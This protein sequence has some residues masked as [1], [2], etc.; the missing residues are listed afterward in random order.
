MPARPRPLLRVTRDAPRD[1][2]DDFARIRAE[3]EVPEAFPAEVE[4]AARDAAGRAVDPAGRDDLRDLAFFTVDPPG[5]MDLDQAMHLERDGDGYRVRYAIA[6]VAA[7]VDR[8]GPVE[9]EAWK[10]G[11]TIYSPDRRTPL[12]PPALSEGAGSL[13]PE[14]ERPA[15]LFTI[16]LDGRGCRRRTTVR[17]ALVRSAARRT[18]EEAGADGGGL[19]AEVGRL[20]IERERKRDGFRLNAPAQVVVA[21]DSCRCGYRVELDRRLPAEDW[22]EQISLLAGMAA[23]GAM[24]GAGVGLVRTLEDMDD[25]ARRKLLAIAAGLGIDPRDGD[26]RALLDSLDPNRPRHAAL[27]RQARELLGHAA[28]RA[29]AGGAPGDGRHAGI[30]AHYAHATAPLRRL[31]DRYVL[32]LLVALDAGEA[33]SAADVETL[34]RLPETMAAA[35]RRAARVERA[36][37]DAAEARTLAD[38]VGET[39]DAVVVDVDDRGAAIQIAEPPVAG[40]L[41]AEPAPALGTRVNVRLEAAEPRAREIRFVPA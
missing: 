35:D 1:L 10:R 17:R 27:Q 20:R 37:V 9:A 40:R 24:V 5:S 28:Y 29:F 3:V 14:E 2:C 7:F 16:E 34:E 18:Y 6:D 26:V 31:A 25:W 38:R 12:Y 13:L 4:A 21:D 8:G 32:D 15:V 19:L 36:S 39:F 41:R 11:L 23:A 22:N 33:P 30:G